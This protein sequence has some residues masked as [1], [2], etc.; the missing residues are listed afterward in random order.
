M[1]GLPWR[2]IFGSTVLFIISVLFFLF[3]VQ[4][5]V[6]QEV[7]VWTQGLTGTP[8][9]EGAGG[10]VYTLLSVEEVGNVAVRIRLP[11]EP[12]YDTGAPLVVYVPTF[13]TPD[14]RVFQELQGLS[15]VGFAQVS[16]L[17]PG[18]KDRETDLGSD[19][20]VDYG[21][22]NSAAALREV[23]LYVSGQKTDVDGKYIQDRST[24]DLDTDIVGAYAFS[25]PGILLFQTIAQFGDRFSLDF[26]VS[27]ESPTEP[28]LSSL[29]LGHYLRGKA[30]LN[31]Q[32]VPAV[33]YRDDG[34]LLSYEDIA[35][36][37]QDDRPYFDV[38]KDG[39][40]HSDDDILFGP[41]VP[42]MFGKKVYSPELLEALRENELFVAAQ[43]PEDLATP[44]EAHLWWQGRESLSVFG[45]IAQVLPDLP[46]MLV[47]SARDHV[48]PSVDKPHI[49]QAYAGL[50]GGGTWV[51]LNPDSV[52]VAL[53][54]ELLAKS[55]TEHSA[56]TGPTSWI[57]EAEAW[58]HPVGANA[59]RVIPFAALM[60]MADRVK[61]DEW[62]GDLSRVLFSP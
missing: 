35:W 39:V 17:L 48:Q 7:P 25:H 42:R 6:G 56:S 54:D 41:Q 55:Y 34:I 14:Q 28:L 24:V 37:A 13:F 45:D 50:T 19:G 26:V 36:D 31:T 43:W 10:V 27:R 9:R 11:H 52:Y 12:R 53:F 62:S 49:R 29:E 51:R 2:M 3:I 8:H 33:H 44:E 16:V 15:D 47:F 46:V 59:S 23:F 4:R 20:E 40:A 1:W 30:I 5:L 38:N 32:Y 57:E 21:G 22:V 60:E 18:R 58:G 61:Y